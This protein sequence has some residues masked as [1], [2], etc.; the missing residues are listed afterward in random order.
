[1][2]TIRISP[3]IKGLIALVLVIAAMKVFFDYAPLSYGGEMLKVH[4]ESLKI[5][6]GWDFDCLHG[7]RH[8]NTTKTTQVTGDDEE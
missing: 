8:V 1:M 3:R 2:V 5:R 6:N 4:C 7:G